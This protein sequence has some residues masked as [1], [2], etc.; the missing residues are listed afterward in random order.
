MLLWWFCTVA[1][2]LKQLLLLLL[3]CC[4]AGYLIIESVYGVEK[5]KVS[6]FFLPPPQ[7]PNMR[8]DRPTGHLVLLRSKNSGI[9]LEV[10]LRTYEGTSVEKTYSMWKRCKR[11]K[12]VKKNMLTDEVEGNNISIFYFHQVW[13][14]SRS[15]VA[16][17]AQCHYK[18]SRAIAQLWHHVRGS[19]NSFF[20]ICD[21]Q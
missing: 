2:F 13:T 15:V 14:V 7:P 10:M 19:K 18:K 5:W 12:L 6:T 9:K 20:I 17:L 21:F 8:I 1:K 3:S 11:Q 16:V 4:Q